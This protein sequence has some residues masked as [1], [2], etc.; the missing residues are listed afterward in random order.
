MH[1]RGSGE[2]GLLVLTHACLGDVCEEFLVLTDIE[3]VDA[4]KH[5]RARYR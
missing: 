4:V 2:L 3:A 1:G 5:W